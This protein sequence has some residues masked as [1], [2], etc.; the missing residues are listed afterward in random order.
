LNVSSL[1]ADRAV[2][3]GILAAHRYALIVETLCAAAW[4]TT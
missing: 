3:A 2:I 4:P 1:P